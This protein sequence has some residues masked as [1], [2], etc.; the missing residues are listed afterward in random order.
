[1]LE[2]LLGIVT[3]EIHNLNLPPCLRRSQ[4]SPVGGSRGVTIRPGHGRAFL[5]SP[6]AWW[7][8]EVAFPWDD[9]T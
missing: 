9:M 7:V 8:P 2:N 3:G 4:R 6:L 5:L 1:M